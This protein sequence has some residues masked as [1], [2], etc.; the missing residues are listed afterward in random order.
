MKILPRPRSIMRKKTKSLLSYTRK[1]NCKCSSH[2]TTTTNKKKVKSFKESNQTTCF[3]SIVQNFFARRNR[4]IPGKHYTN[5]VRQLHFQGVDTR[6]SL[7]Q[8]PPQGK[9][10]E[11][12]SCNTGHFLPLHLLMGGMFHQLN[13]TLMFALSMDTH[14]RTTLCILQHSFPNICCHIYLLS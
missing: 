1:G 6:P 9:L 5:I 13:S 14:A 7:W 10:L 2:K 3:K 8:L 12:C 11:H 4:V